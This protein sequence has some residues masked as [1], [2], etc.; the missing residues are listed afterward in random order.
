MNMVIKEEWNYVLRLGS[1][2]QTPFLCSNSLKTHKNMER[3][4]DGP[5]FFLFICTYLKD[6]GICCFNLNVPF[7]FSMLKRT[8]PKYYYQKSSASVRWMLP[9][10]WNCYASIASVVSGTLIEIPKGWDKNK[11]CQ[12]CVSEYCAYRRRRFRFGLSAFVWLMNLWQSIW[13]WSCCTQNPFSVSLSIEVL[14]ARHSEEPLHA[15]HWTVYGEIKTRYACLPCGVL[16]KIF[17]KIISTDYCRHKATT[18]K[19]IESHR[20]SVL[21]V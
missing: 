1:L 5:H 4:T 17:C 21:F 12:A 13:I 10:F 18:L 19:R 7:H 6:C 15:V 20:V 8:F 14:S 11:H 3:K 2:F 9:L 16:K